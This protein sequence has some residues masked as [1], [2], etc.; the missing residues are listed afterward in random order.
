MMR[1]LRVSRRA[2]HRLN[3]EPLLRKSLLAK[4]TFKFAYRQL[5]S[6]GE[7]EIRLDGYRLR[8][9][10][11]DSYIAYSLL[12]LGAYEPFQTRVFQSYLTPK[13]VVVDVGAHVGYY[14]LMAA[15]VA[16]QVYSFEPCPANCEQLKANIQ[17][18]GFTNVVVNQSAVSDYNGT[19]LLYL[20]HDLNTGHNSLAPQV[21]GSAVSVEVVSIDQ[22]MRQCSGRISLVKTD[23]EGGDAGV[24]RGMSRTLRENRPVVFAEFDPENIKRTGHDPREMLDSLQSAGYRLSVIDE[25]QKRV[26]A[27]TPSTLLTTLSAGAFCSILAESET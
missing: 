8:I 4:R 26:S 1:L 25:D 20:A 17:L 27:I 24:L 10:A 19:A 18:N 3:I 11:R 6:N 12:T 21:G 15:T 22:V 9:D 5:R 2:V 23:T 14:T 7:V 13:A 16:R